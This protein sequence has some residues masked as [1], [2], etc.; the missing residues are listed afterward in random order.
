MVKA[1]PIVVGRVSRV[2]VLIDDDHVR[3]R[4][5]IKAL[6]MWMT[7]RKVLIGIVGDGMREI[8]GNGGCRWCSSDGRSYES[9][10]RH[11]SSFWSLEYHGS[12][13]DREKKETMGV[14]AMDNT[15]ER[16]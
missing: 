4:Q 3:W 11:V 16:I 9:R 13:Y 1:V 14:G 6:L 12:L 2:I 8:G 7:A 10:D 15:V 5:W